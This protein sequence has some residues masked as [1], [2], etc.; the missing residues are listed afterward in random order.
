MLY[1]KIFLIFGKFSSVMN[2][3]KQDPEDKDTDLTTYAK[4]CILNC[5]DIAFFKIAHSFYFVNI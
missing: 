3:D 4:T 2:K 5:Y 1:F